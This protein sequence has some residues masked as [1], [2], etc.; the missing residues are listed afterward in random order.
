MFT[1]PGLLRSVLWNA[2]QDTAGQAHT[3]TH[4][5]RQG[6]QTP[7]VVRDEPE[8]SQR[9][10]RPSCTTVGSSGQSQGR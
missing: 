5:R 3:L 1:N 10:G 2:Q 4:D 6:T 7:P 8:Q 9:A